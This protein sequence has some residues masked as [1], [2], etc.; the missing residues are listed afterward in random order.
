MDRPRDHSAGAVRAAAEKAPTIWEIVQ[1]PPDLVATEVEAF[2]ELVRTFHLAHG[3]ASSR[4]SSLG[5]TPP[6]FGMLVILSTRPEGIEQDEVRRRLLCSRPNLSGLA[7]RLVRMGAIA[8]DFHPK[9]RRKRILRL[10]KKGKELFKSAWKIQR[11]TVEA[12]LAP[13]TDE[14][15]RALAGLLRKI[16]GPLEEKRRG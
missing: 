16:R 13:L 5:I 9:D 3:F 7:D 11:P 6:Q 12:I 4:L 15:R 2:L 8:R 10:T 14:E 1:V